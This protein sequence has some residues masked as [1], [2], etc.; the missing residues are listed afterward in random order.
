[1]FKVLR[2]LLLTLF[3]IGSFL[4]HADASEKCAAYLSL[5]HEEGFAD[6]VRDISR[7]KF[8]GLVK[9]HRVVIFQKAETNQ[10]VAL[11]AE[12][13]LK[14]QEDTQTVDAFVKRFEDIAVELVDSGATDIRKG[15]STKASSNIVRSLFLD[16][17]ENRVHL[18]DK[19]IPEILNP[20]NVILVMM[21][22]FTF[23]LAYANI[24]MLTSPGPP[25]LWL[26]KIFMP[27]LIVSVPLKIVAGGVF[28][29]ALDVLLGAASHLMNTFKV[30]EY[31]PVTNF[32]LNKRNIFMVQKISELMSD[33]EVKRERLVAIVGGM[34]L[35]QMIVEMKKHGFQQVHLD[36]ILAGK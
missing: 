30:G 26:P 27:P 25:D 11:L 13:H 35:R 9:S 31:L 34:H 24:A 4:F 8:L 6:A 28:F 20:V 19:K 7:L 2:K 23:F 3:F 14:K 29:Y 32:M 17:S 36:S 5:I 15:W 33:P 12:T 18:I 22:G 21:G 1:V 10:V 16:S